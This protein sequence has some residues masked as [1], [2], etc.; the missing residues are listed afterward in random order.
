ML[1]FR[2]DPSGSIFEES[3]DGKRLLRLRPDILFHLYVS[4]S[5]CGDARIFAASD[6]DLELGQDPH[7]NRQA[8]GVLRTKIESGEGTIPVTGTGA[9]LQTWD[10][11]QLGERLLTMS[12]SD[13]MARWNVV[14]V[15]GSLL[16]LLIEPVYLSTVIVGSLFHKAHLER[17]LITR[18]D[19]IRGLPCPFRLAR[20]VLLRTDVV[21]SDRSGNKDR[22][23]L[24]APKH[25]IC[26]TA[27]WTD[28]ECVDTAQGLAFSHFDFDF[29]DFFIFD[30]FI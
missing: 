16:S 11:V 19:A 9:L 2:N 7:P 5:P 29:F 28:V 13:K 3:A 1:V 15:Q 23:P 25:S 12:C 18:I 24:K 26:W 22:Q 14:G 30:S 6:V 27:G 4:S 20:P 17:A 10:G 8:R 21:G